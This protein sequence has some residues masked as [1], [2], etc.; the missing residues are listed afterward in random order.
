[1]DISKKEWFDSLDPDLQPV[2]NTAAMT[3][4]TP[5]EII[6]GAALAYREVQQNYNNSTSADIGSYINFASP[7]AEDATPSV[8]NT[9]VIS[10]NKTITLRVKTVYLPQAV[11]QPQQSVTII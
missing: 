6:F 8:D 3:N 7:V 1:M 9:G 10:K 11:I 5:S 2:F 4:L